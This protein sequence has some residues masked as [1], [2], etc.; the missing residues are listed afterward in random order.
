MRGGGTAGKG[1]GR[2]GF[3]VAGAALCAGVPARAAEG[4][5]LA[6]IDWAML[7]SVMALGLLPVGAT[8][9]IQFRRNA[10][11]P[12]IPTEVVDL[13]LR[14]SPNLELLRALEP[15]HILIS[16]F[17]TRHQKAMEA[18]APVLSL[19]F[20][21]RGEPPFAKALAAVER[22]GE[23]FDRQT[24][25][26]AVLD[27]AQAQLTAMRTRLAPVADRPS[28]VI[29]IGDARHFRAFGHDSMFGDIL[30]RLGLPNAWTDRSRFSFAA[31]VPL[32]MLAS[33]PEARI[34]IVSRIPVEARSGFRNSMIWNALAPVRAGDV[35]ELDNVNPYGGVTA[36]LRFARLLT[37]ALSGRD[38]QDGAHL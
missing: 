15:D 13:G 29:N 19:P 5:R 22:L 26:T 3:L 38:P 25:A 34:V 20:Y 2:R 32:E 31:P 8:E 18:I 1:L 21:Q 10:V 28:F 37:E 6:A 14:G 30:A 7:E 24:K 35:I 16:P 33:R 17:Y 9:L 36:G 4:P 12:A 27:G 23:I 11:E